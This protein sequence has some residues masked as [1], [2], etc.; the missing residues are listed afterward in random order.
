MLCLICE[1]S[2]KSQNVLYNLSN[3]V[4]VYSVPLKV[5]CFV[6]CLFIW[7]RYI[8]VICLNAL[9]VLDHFEL[10]TFLNCPKITAT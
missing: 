10:Q 4:S 6:Y 2:A 3:R 7:L 9:F 1:S 5:V 8:V